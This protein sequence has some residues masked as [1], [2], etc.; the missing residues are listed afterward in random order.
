MKALEFATCFK[1]ELADICLLKA[2]KVMYMQK[3]EQ[4]QSFLIL[5]SLVSSR[6][7]VSTPV[8]II[9]HCI[10]KPSMIRAKLILMTRPSIYLRFRMVQQIDKSLYRIFFMIL[11]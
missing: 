4:H 2:I 1:L 11:W 7:I 8:K 3:F 6:V 10:N 9:L 5:L